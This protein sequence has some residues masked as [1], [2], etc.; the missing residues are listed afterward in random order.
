MDKEIPVIPK[1]LLDFLVERYG[2]DRY[3]QVGDLKDL[4]RV[5]GMRH[6]V[7][8][9]SYLY[10]KQNTPKLVQPRKNI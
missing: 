9:L 10:K 2:I 5:Q 3:E 4:H 8:D 6:V 1:D 7:S